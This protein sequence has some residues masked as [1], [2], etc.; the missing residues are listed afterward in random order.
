M[1]PSVQRYELFWKQVKCTACKFKCDFQKYY[2]ELGKEEEPN[3]NFCKDRNY[4]RGLNLQLLFE[5]FFNWDLWYGT[6]LK[7]REDQLYEDI[8]FKD[9][10]VEIVE[11]LGTLKF[12]SDHMK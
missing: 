5:N 2:V 9:F 3:R 6:F 4:S 11:K 1:G 12:F 8:L 7:I 10:Q